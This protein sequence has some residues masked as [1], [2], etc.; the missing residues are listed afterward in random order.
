MTAAGARRSWWGLIGAGHLVLLLSLL[1]SV[2]Y[3]DHWSE[4]LFPNRPEHVSA[5]DE[6]LHESHCHFGSGSCSQPVPTNLKMLVSVV[7]L[8]QLELTVTAI[9][10]VASVIEEAFITPPTEPPRAA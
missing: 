6:A 10:D 7:D 3:L 5:A 8:P 4:F 2:L 1:P 9:E